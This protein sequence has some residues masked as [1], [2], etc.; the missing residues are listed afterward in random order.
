MFQP[1]AIARLLFFRVDEDAW[2]ALKT[3]LEYV[4]LMPETILPI[5]GRL[6]LNSSIPRDEVLWRIL[7][8]AVEN[9]AEAR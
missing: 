1:A 3:V 4:N 2:S 6:I 7:Q 9:H 8:E 5:D